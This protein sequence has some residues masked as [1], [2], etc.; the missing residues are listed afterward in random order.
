MLSLTQTLRSRVPFVAFGVALALPLPV[1]PRSPDSA[2]ATV[3]LAGGCFWG[4]E[5][6]YRHVKGVKSAVSGFA[7]P[8]AAEGAEPSMMSTKPAYAEAVRIEYDPAVVN[9]DQ[10]MAVFFT[11]AHDPTQVGRQGPD[12]GPEYRSVIFV[13]SDD[14]RSHAEQSL[15]RFKSDGRFTKPITTEIAKLKTFKVAGA[16]HQDYVARN[17]RSPYVVEVDLPKLAHLQH[18]FPELYK[19]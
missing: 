7:V 16:E 5:A 15:A 9:Y 6:V 19:K 17:P 10:L 4:V 14:E 11:V 18:A 3:V 13:T 12:I 8:E 2:K 1:S